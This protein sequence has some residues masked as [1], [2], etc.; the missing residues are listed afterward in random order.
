MG[1]CDIVYVPIANPTRGIWK[2][3]LDNR[4]VLSFH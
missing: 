2:P 3:L 1:E 4:S